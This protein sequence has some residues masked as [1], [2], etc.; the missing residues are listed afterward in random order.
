MLQTAGGWTTDLQSL[1]ATHR[2]LGLAPIGDGL[3]AWEAPELVLV[4]APRWLDIDADAP[5]H[6]VHAGPLN[7][8]RPDD[9]RPRDAGRPSVLLTF[10]TTLMEGQMA[11]IDRA[12]RAVA[13]LELDAILTLGPAV[14]RDA[15]HAPD[16]IQVLPFA[17]H[18]RVVPGCAAV[19]SHG[20][21]GTVLRALAHGV[22]QLLLALGRDQ[23]FNASRVEALRAGIQ[24]P[25][26]APPEMI[27]TALRT[28]LADPRFST[29]A[30]RAAS[31]IAAEDPDRKA[32]EALERIAHRG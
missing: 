17:D 7:V 13:G 22:P 11:L 6:V 9:E 30:A 5:D 18:D 8:A 31:R 24:L 25:T 29:A 27:A 23:A 26:Q 21:L 20:G 4:G 28:L 12:C 3:T 32:A 10:S 14:D 19:I 2:T 1:A 16:G 15:V